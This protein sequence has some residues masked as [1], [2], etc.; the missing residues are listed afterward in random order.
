MKLHA[1]DMKHKYLI[2]FF[3]LASLP[4]L[5]CHEVWAGEVRRIVSLG[6]VNTENVFLLGAGDRLV[7]DTIYCVRPE[8]AK[9]KVKVGS[10]IQVSVEKIISLQPDLV[11]ATAFTKPA[12]VKQLQQAGFR[13]IRF[14]RPA[15]FSEICSQ[16]IELGRLLNLEDKAEDVVLQAQHEVTRIQAEVADLPLQKVFLQ[17]GSIPLFGS[18]PESFTNDFIVLAGGINILADQRQ[19]TTNVEKVIAANPDVIIIAIMGFESGVAGDE[20]KKWQAISILKAT[21]TKRI[22]IINP[23][24]V[25][26]PSPA[27]FAQTLGVMAEL[28]H[29]GIDLVKADNQEVEIQ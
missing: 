28:I 10:V 13:V 6:P 18:I 25:C 15:S 1:I 9:S 22:W 27:T 11:L 14:M 2:L 29:P 8:A 23:D 16:F 24:L 19:G 20:Q 21:R 5:C 17:V 26:S 3:M 7:G 4:G 12:Q